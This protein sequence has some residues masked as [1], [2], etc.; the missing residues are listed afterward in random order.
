MDKKLYHIMKAIYCNDISW[1]TFIFTT[2]LFLLDAI[3]CYY[4]LFILTEIS[5]S[6]DIASTGNLFRNI[7]ALFIYHLSTIY[8]FIYQRLRLTGMSNECTPFLF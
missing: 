4:L 6:W 5:Y 3:I 1:K 8:L 7:S 2:M